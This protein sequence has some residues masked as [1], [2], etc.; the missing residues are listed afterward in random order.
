MKKCPSG[1]RAFANEQLA[2]EALLG[3]H[4]HFDYRRG[5]GPVSYY[6]CSDCAELHLTSTGAMNPRLAEAIANG[7]LKRDK[8]ARRWED[9]FR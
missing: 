9:K 6:Q 8:E 3:A 2:E 5:N 7:S 4:I 1:K